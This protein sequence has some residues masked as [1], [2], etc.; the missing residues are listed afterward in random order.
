[1]I[2]VKNLPEAR[3]KALVEDTERGL[4]GA[5]EPNA[6]Q[7]DTCIGHW[8]YNR[9]VYDN[10]E[11]KSAPEV[12]HVL[13]DTVA[14]NGNLLLSVPVRSDGTI[15]E[16]ETAIVEGIASWMGRFSEAIYGTRPWKTSGEGPTEVAVGAFNESKTKA[17]AAADI[18]FTTKAG[19]LYAMTLGKPEGNVTIASLKG[20]KVERVEVV[21]SPAPLAFKQDGGGLHVVLPPAANHDFGVALKIRGKGLV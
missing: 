6:W 9:K 18:R 13:C 8:H 4:R 17:F 20:A 7:T 11:Y 12:V 1:M 10:N 5:I 14:K 2:N 16:R 21:G 3:R 15:D 19:A